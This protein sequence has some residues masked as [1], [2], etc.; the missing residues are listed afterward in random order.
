MFETRDVSSWVVHSDEP[1]GSKDKEWLRSVPAGELWLFK[2]C[3][4]DAGDDWAEKAAEQLANLIRLPHAQVELA[5]RDGSR[6]VIS[7]DF[8]Q[9]NRETVGVFVPGNELLWEADASYPKAKTRGAP[10]Y[11]V[12]RSLD[13][14]R[15]E[16]T[17]SPKTGVTFDET[18]EAAWFF[19]GY[20]LFDA[21]IGNL[22]RHHENWGVLTMNPDQKSP[23]RVMGPSFDHGSSLGQNETDEKR[24][25]RLVT[26]DKHGTIEAWARSRAV[27][28]FYRTESDKKPCTTM[29]AFEV[30][31]ARYPEAARLW[32]DRL[33]SVDS[34]AVKEVLSAVPGPLLSD[35]GLEFTLRLLEINRRDLLTRFSS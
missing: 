19:V 3:R 15:K 5:T 9:V 7:R 4:S 11:T 24:K 1:L 13:I 14:L 27:S 18:M 31:A 33:A 2:R 23:S 22:D 8:R 12:D 35:I 21:W 10:Q 17:L 29:D 16:E 28:R 25:L 34:R 6:G 32:L 20:L 30:A 26:K